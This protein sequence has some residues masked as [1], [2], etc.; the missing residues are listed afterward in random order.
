M[1]VIVASCVFPPEPVVSAKTSMDVARYLHD[2]GHE[3]VVACPTPSRNIAKADVERK[4]S[5][6]PQ[7]FKVARLSALA[8]KKSGFFSR[9]IENISFGLSV[10]IFILKQRKVDLVY[11]NVWPVFSLGLLVLACRIKG[12]KVVASIQDLYP[13]SLSA[14]KR[15]KETS[16]IFKT[17][18]FLDSWIAKK[19]DHI[20]VISEGFKS[21]FVERRGV[22]ES[23]VTVIRNWVKSNQVEVCDRTEART[24]LARHLSITLG[25][26]TFVCVYGGNMGVASGLDELMQHVVL[27]KKDVLFVLAGDGSLVPGL[28]ELVSKSGCESKVKFIVPWPSE[29]TSLVFGAAD[30]LLLPI[31]AGQEWAS[32]PSKLITYM[33]SSRPIML[34]TNK[35]SESAIELEKS[36][37]GFCVEDRTDQAIFSCLDSLMELSPQERLSMGTSGRKY[38]ENFYSSDVALAKINKI[39]ES[40]V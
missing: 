21:A 18:F 27:F 32:V 17:L 19:C 4:I 12:I 37:A 10:F 5:E 20:V 9:F 29:M 40:L 33:L 1:K 28:R 25:D 35:R 14:Q 36:G 15:L 38:A 6:M 2:E 3:V 7:P 8:S 30:V 23:K 39:F 34:L 22:K 16:A 24:E 13:E 26:E 11:A 31:A